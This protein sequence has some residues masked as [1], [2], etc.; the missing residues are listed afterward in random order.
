MSA[1]GRAPTPTPN[2]AQ[3]ARV[4]RMYHT[5][6]EAYRALGVNDARLNDLAAEYGIQ[7]PSAR[8]KADQQGAAYAP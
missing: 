5:N 8:N 4:C 3:I 2:E 1:Q 7:T 6:K